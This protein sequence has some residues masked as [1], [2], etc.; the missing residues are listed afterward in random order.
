M[1]RH[2]KYGGLNGKQKSC[3]LLEKPLCEC[4][5]APMFT[6]ASADTQNSSET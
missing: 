6:E 1:G 2:E 5:G 3:V 4:S